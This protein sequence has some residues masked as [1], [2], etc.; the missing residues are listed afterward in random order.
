M[1]PELLPFASPEHRPFKLGS[2]EGGVL[3][4]H[5]F[6]GTPAEMRGIA[7]KLV[8]TGWHARGML[9]PGFG[10]EIANLNHYRRSE[11]LQAATSEWDQLIREHRHPVLLGFSMGATLALHLSRFLAPEKLILIA[12]F[13]HAPGWLAKSLPIAAKLGLK[14]KPFKK[15]DF[16]DSLLQEQFERIMPGINLE[17]P[18]IQEYI[19]KQFTLPINALNEVLR[20]GHQAY[21]NAIM[22]KM[23][24][25]IIQGDRDPVVLPEQTRRLVE[26]IPAEY[27]TYH[28]IPGEHNLLAENSTQ[29]SETTE[30][31][32]EFLE[33]S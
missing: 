15:A 11:W 8:L 7:D 9:L 26:R 25:L 16:N 19:R 32:L 17:N 29:A 5:G 4:I 28:E 30:L 3:L 33:Q 12:P 27:A 6:T 31:I 1:I 23:P 21:R 13:W 10:P 20:L 22:V 18:E 24:T 14:L 2:G